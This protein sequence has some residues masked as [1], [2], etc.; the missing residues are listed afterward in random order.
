MENNDEIILIYTGNT[1]MIQRI[2][3]E[4]EAQGIYCLVKDGYKQGIEAG[5]VGGTSSTIDLFVT[6]TD[7]ENAQKIVKAIID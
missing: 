2:K 4:L 3:A 5:F 7:F 6:D 1:L